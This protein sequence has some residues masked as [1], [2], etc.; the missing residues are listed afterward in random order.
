MHFGMYSFHMKGNTGH[1]TKQINSFDLNK[2]ALRNPPSE[3]QVQRRKPVYP[4]PQR[5]LYFRSGVLRVHRPSAEGEK[6]TVFTGDSTRYC[7]IWALAQSYRKPLEFFS[8]LVTTDGSEHMYK[9]LE[10][11]MWKPA[12]CTWGFLSGKGQVGPHCKLLRV[13]KTIAYEH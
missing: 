12:I 13:I 9:Q 7:L 11:V 2:N 3:R 4:A 10:F 1:V 8:V 6:S 5:E